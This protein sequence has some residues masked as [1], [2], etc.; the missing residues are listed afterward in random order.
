M[1]ARLTYCPPDTLYSE[2]S[3]CAK[4][5]IRTGEDEYDVEMIT[6]CAACTDNNVHPIRGECISNPT[7][8]AYDCSDDEKYEG[9]LM[10]RNQELFR[11]DWSYCVE[12]QDGWMMDDKEGECFEVKSHGDCPEDTPWRVEGS[13]STCVASC[14][15]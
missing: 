14:N 7:T 2:C 12:C 13:I 5:N 4:A 15:N 10:C 1:E 11:P 9:C 3:F 6:F 8:G